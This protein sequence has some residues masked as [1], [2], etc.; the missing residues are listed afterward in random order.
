MLPGENPPQSLSPNPQTGNRT[1]TPLTSGAP[2]QEPPISCGSGGGIIPTTKRGPDTHVVAATGADGA[3][4][5]AGAVGR[6]VTPGQTGTRG[7]AVD[8]ESGGFAG[9]GADAGTAGTAGA[10]GGTGLTG[11]GGGGAET[12]GAEAS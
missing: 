10:E 4:L 5:P 11:T 2:Q 8:A 9:G 1:I 3:D 7:V 6:I 12:V